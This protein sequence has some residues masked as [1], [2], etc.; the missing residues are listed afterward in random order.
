MTITFATL[1]A[2]IVRSEITVEPPGT[3]TMPFNCST[4]VFPVITHHLYL[5]HPSQLRECKRT[6]PATPM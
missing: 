3:G 5:E 2:G 6:S 1:L 4:S